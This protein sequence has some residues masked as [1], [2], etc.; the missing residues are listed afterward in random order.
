MSNGQSHQAK[1]SSDPLPAL[2]PWKTVETRD[3]F[4]AMPWLKV[5]V[6]RVELPDGRA[7]DDFYKVYMPDSV[8]VFA[9][10]DDGRAVVERAYRHGIGRVSLVFPTGGIGDGEA[11]LA[12]ARRELLEE[13]GYAAREWRPLGSFRANGNQGCGLIHMFQATGARRVEEPHG[14]DLEE[15]QTVLMTAE[16]LV[17]ALARGEIVAL[18]SVA[19]VG[20]ALGDLGG[21][22]DDLPWLPGSDAIHRT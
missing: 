6:E 14:D 16:D 2:Q 1:G 19:A 17:G 13:T 18:S 4:S 15:I 8:L 5:S 10:T 21:P 9:R 3:V 22:T 20:L 11:P 12:A 7:V